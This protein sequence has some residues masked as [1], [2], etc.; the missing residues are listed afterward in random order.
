MSNPECRNCRF[1]FTHN[2]NHGEG[3]CRRHA[4]VWLGIITTLKDED[5]FGWPMTQRHNW[6]GDHVPAPEAGEPRQEEKEL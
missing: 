1:W 4:P 2:V 5:N 6:C 3:R